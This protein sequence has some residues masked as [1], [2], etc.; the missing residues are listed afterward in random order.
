MC[1]SVFAID[2]N[3]EEELLSAELLKSDTDDVN[4]NGFIVLK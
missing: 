4:F 3:A 2:R 1:A